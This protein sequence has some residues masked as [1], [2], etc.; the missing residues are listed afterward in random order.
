MGDDGGLSFTDPVRASSDSGDPIPGVT[1]LP[2]IVFAG[3]DVVVVTYANSLD[4]LSEHVFAASSVDGGISFGFTHELMD[5]GTGDALTPVVVEASGTGL[6]NGAC[7]GWTDFR[8]GSGING[9][10]QIRRVGQ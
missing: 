2:Q 10:I 5:T 4:G 7:I 6:N 3:G 1:R 9:D 8:A